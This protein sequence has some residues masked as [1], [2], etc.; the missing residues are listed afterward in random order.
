MALS[1]RRKW[2]ELNY[3]G[4]LFHDLRRSAVRDLIRAGVSARVAMSISGH[5]T[6]SMLRRYGIVDTATS[7]PRLSA[8]RS[9]SRLCAARV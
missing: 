5:K 4:R 3:A 7:G 1:T 8:V 9:T 2:E 6:D